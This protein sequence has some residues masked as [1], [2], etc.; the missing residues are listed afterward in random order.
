[1]G[2]GTIVANIVMFISVLILATAVLGVFKSTIDS[3]VTSL[4]VRSDEIS[5]SILTDITIESAVYDN[6]SEE[7]VVSVKN[8]GDT[9]LDPEYIDVYVDNFFVPRNAANRSIQVQPSTDTRNSGLFDPRELLEVK[10]GKPLDN[11]THHYVAIATQYGTKTEEL[12]T[13]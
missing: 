6:V 4:N 10:I 9:V 3:S 13:I 1:M 7:I 2:F 8:T 11:D 12:I 5:N